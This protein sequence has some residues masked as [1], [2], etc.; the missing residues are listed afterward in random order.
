MSLS[1][2]S[3][4][5]ELIL[6]STIKPNNAQLALLNANFLSMGQSEKT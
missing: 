3:I 4:I 2:S 6:I 5:N 1:A